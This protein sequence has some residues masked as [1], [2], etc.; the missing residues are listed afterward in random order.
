MVRIFNVYYPTRTVV[1]LL[2]EALIVSTSFLLATAII[3]GPDTYIVLNY[4]YGMLKIAGITGLTI[5]CSYYFDLYEPQSISARWEIY[6]R[7]LV[8]LGLLAI[9]LSAIIYVFP[10]FAIAPYIMPLGLTFLTAALVAWRSAYEWIIGSPIFAERVYVLGDGELAQTIARTIRTRRDSGM[11]LV[12]SINPVTSH[13]VTSHPVTGDPVTGNPVTGNPVTGNP[14]TAGMSR[15]ESFAAMLQSFSG[16]KPKIDRVIVAMEDRREGLPVR[17]LLRLRF[18]GVIIEEAGTLLERLSCKLQ[19]SNLHP[20]SFIYAEGFRLKPSQLIS[21]RIVSMIAAALGLLIIAPLL[22]IVILLVRLSSPGPIFYRQSR[23]GLRGKTFMVLKFRTMR[24]DAEAN[25]AKWATKDD[26]RVTPIGRFMRKTRLDEVPQ[27]WN[28]LRGDM[29]F[30]GPRPERP[31]FVPLLS[32]EMPFYHLRHTIRPGLTGWAQVRYGYG[33]TLEE[34]R[35]KL[36]FDLYYL[37]HMSLG[38]DLLIMFETVKTILRRR[39]GQ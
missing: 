33:G 20:S 27:L 26:P 37:K 16:P 38:L 14:I 28:I 8:V 7:L 4:E 1:L 39:G 24:Q 6:F 21:R 5:L 18:D 35:H 30:V 32:E 13:P 36:E 17:E 34:S 9:I 29:N 3:V 15:K 2:C 12:E 23:V 31:E 10:A 25:G 22:P 11:E 19:L